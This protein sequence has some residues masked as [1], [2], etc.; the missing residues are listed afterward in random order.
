MIT[1][2]NFVHLFGAKIP[3]VVPLVSINMQRSYKKITFGLIRFNTTLFLSCRFN[4]HG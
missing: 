2:L 1:L 4:K 3:A